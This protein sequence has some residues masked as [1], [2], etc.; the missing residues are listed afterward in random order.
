MNIKRYK[1]LL[2]S[3]FLLL[4][5]FTFF[6]AYIFT[7]YMKDSENFIK[8]IMMK[9]SIS[10]YNSIVTMR[11]WNAS[12]GGVYVKQNDRV[13]PNKYI[14]DNQLIT[15]DNKVL[16]KVNPTWMTRQISELSNKKNQYYF[17]ITSLD[18]INLVN[19]ADDFEREALEYFDKYRDKKYYAKISKDLSKFDFMG[20]LKIT[21]SCLKC[22]IEQKYQIGDIRGGIR[23]SIPTEDYYKEFLDVRK[24]GKFL[25]ALVFI[26]STVIIVVLIILLRKLSKNNK[27]IQ[28]NLERI[29]SLKEV[30][31]EL[32][33][34][35]EKAIEGSQGG[36]WDWNLINDEVYF[37]KR[38][39]EMIGYEE[40][41]MENSFEEWEEKIHPDDKEEVIKDILANQNKKTDYYENIHRLRHKN[42]S[43]VWILD[44]GKTF[45]DKNGKAKR[46]MGFHTDITKMKNLELELEAT[47]KELLDFRILIESAP[48]SIVITD[49]TGN[50]T[51]VNPYF[52]K[53]SGYEENE[54]LGKNPRFLKPENE[55]DNTKF[56]S[57]WSNITNKKTWSGI[58]RNRK[59]DGSEYWET[60]VILPVLDTN[61][62]IMNYLGIMREITKEVY[63]EKELKEKEELMLSQSR[64]AAL[65]D[66]I[67]M[68]AHQWRQ[69]I[70][71]ISMSVNNI[72]VDFELDI[73]NKEEIKK[74]VSNISK[75]TEY[76]SKTIDDFRNFFKKD[77]EAKS[78][79]IKELIDEISSIMLA[80]IEGN[81]IEFDL[82]GVDQNMKLFT[83]KRELLQVLLNIIKN[84]KEA[85]SNSSKD[86]KIK[87]NILKDN[88]NFKIVI[89]DNAGGIK[90]EHLNNIFDAYF[91]TKEQFNGTGLGLYMSKMIVEKHLKGSLS[92][93][94]NNEG[95]V[96]EII[97]SSSF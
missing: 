65:G 93:Y 52:C 74:I 38:L 55:I 21:K 29:K 69:P 7:E 62:E 19:K 83:Y 37:S 80:S 90:N 56:E 44:K 92:A 46:M 86:K 85:F 75:Q 57:L 13:K 64:S 4:I 58:F 14:T 31:D 27:E 61:G 47:K 72:I 48:L 54:V 23:V 33:L 43:W 66:M 63:L 1:T 73:F 41:E 53:I 78:F 10:Y 35:Y 25:I 94:N 91:T 51:Y 36:I 81:G 18:P 76:L 67:S 82:S 96:F 9:E 24:K 2:F 40:H 87:M 50:I 22:H 34:R 89:A 26:L 17:K 59:K 5:S 16:V 84:S 49:F 39:K 88:D 6:I 60:V 42:G 12:F 30:N 32:L 70:T 20:S 71:D 77:R 68:I 45:F 3:I 95:A 79:E 28:N 97:F 15:K 8:E 11:K